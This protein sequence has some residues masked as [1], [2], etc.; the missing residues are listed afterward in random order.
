WRRRGRTPPRRRARRAARGRRPTGPGW[1]PG[2][3]PSKSGSCAPSAAAYR[4]CRACRGLRQ[5]VLAQELH[6]DRPMADERLVERAL[7]ILV[8]D[9]FLV[10]ALEVLDLRQPEEILGE[11]R[12]VELGAQELLLRH[13]LLLEA[14]VD[15][16]AHRLVVAHGARLQLD[17]E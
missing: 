9:L 13:R 7:R 2:R 14:L 15:H 11:L 8:G 17:V 12:R 10:V 16:E 4:E 6:G 3:A 5:E 1:R